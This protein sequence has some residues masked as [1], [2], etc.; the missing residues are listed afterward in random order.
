MFV[1][2]TVENK[3]LMYINIICIGLISNC[4]TLQDLKT[5]PTALVFN[6]PNCTKK[7]NFLG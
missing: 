2:C 6:S 7:E 4:N 1:F 5:N 3:H